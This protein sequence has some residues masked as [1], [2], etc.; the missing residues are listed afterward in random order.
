[1]GATTRAAGDTKRTKD[2][3]RARLAHSRSL[4]VLERSWAAPAAHSCLPGFYFKRLQISFKAELSLHPRA[5]IK[6][7]NLFG[8]LGN[9]VL[10]KSVGFPSAM[11]S[12]HRTTGA[13]FLKHLEKY[14]PQ[15]AHSH[16]VCSD[17]QSQQSKNNSAGFW[18]TFDL[19]PLDSLVSRSPYLI[20]T[21]HFSN[22]LQLPFF[23]NFLR[24][25]ATQWDVDVPK[26]GTEPQPCR[27]NAVQLCVSHQGSPVFN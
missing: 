21:Q 19:N 25:V 26:V 8:T 27:S 13:E 10:E 5:I 2:E 9:S 24:Q 11:C 14:E 6:H 3:G 12:M 4:P 18:G 7:M 20:L 17:D 23:L 15:G 22:C 1:M 16:P